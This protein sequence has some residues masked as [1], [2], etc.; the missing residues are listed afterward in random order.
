MEQDPEQGK[1]ERA[2]NGQFPKGQSG[3]PSGRRKSQAREV[4][5]DGYVN[6]FSGHGT[7]R[8]RR[9][10]TK[11]S[12]NIVTDIQAIDL[13]RGNW[14]A[15]RIC[16][17]LPAEGV[18][19]GINLKMPKNDQAKAVETEIK[20]LGMMKKFKETIQMA[21]CCGGAAIYP[22][23]DGAHGLSSEPLD[24]DTDPRILKVNALHILEPRELV[25]IDWYTDINNP[26]F[27]LPS[28][29]RLWPLQGGRGVPQMIEVH[30]SRLGIFPGVRF[31]REPL[32]GQR[33]GWGDSVL[34]PVAELLADFGLSW[35]SAATIL[36]N[37]SQRVIKLDQ[38]AEILAQKDGETILQK[39]LAAMDMAASTLR[40]ITLDGKDEFISASISVAGLADLLVQMAQVVAASADTPLTRLFGMSPAG[41]NAT[42]E[43]DTRGWYDRVGNE[44]IDWTPTMTWLLRLILLSTEGPTGGVE[45]KDWAMEWPPLMAPSEKEEADRRKTVAETD[46]I[47]YNIGAASDEDIADSRW[48]SDS[49]SAEMNIDWVARKKQRALQA[50]ADKAALEAMGR[51]DPNA[52][53]P[54]DPNAPQPPQDPAPAGA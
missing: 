10:V 1:A 54:A 32:P 53:P 39:R 7:T 46:Q 16:N 22:V 28:S 50:T 9:T 47:Y 35:G 38:L 36:H 42:G 5:R 41:M 6:A 12:S 51:P 23:L 27:S 13:R 15:A 52:P 33:L 25:P 31:T 44:Q 37:F 24:L 14:L 26:K 17:L 40:A 45:P 11:H 48:G 8:D 2:P 20:R 19:R 29:Y 34:M 18:R 3:N 4:R 30:E 49:Y 43:S 21:R